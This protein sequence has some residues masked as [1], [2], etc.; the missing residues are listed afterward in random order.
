[1][2]GVVRVL[3]VDDSAYVRKVVR[4]M[5]SRSPFLEVVGAARDGEE[6]LELVEQLRPDVVTLD[7]N[8]PRLDGLDFLRRQ[9]A[10]RPVPV[11]L[12]SIASESGEQV[13][14]A[15]DAGAV[16][17]VQKPTALASEQVLEVADDLIAKVKAAASAKV[18][19]LRD[20]M[21]PAQP[22]LTSRTRSDRTDIV[23]IGVSTGGPQALKQLIPKL[24][25][26]FPVP[27]AIVLHMPMGFTEL[28]ARSLA[29]ASRLA[30]AEARDGDLVRPRLALIAPSGYHLTFS[31]RSD[32]TVTVCLTLRPLDTPHR[33]AVDVLFRSAA[34]VYGD[35]VLAVVL[36]GM[37]SDG[38]Q[39]AAWVKAQGGRVF[40]EAE[41]SCVV[42][43]MPRSV[44]EAGL[45][46]AYI[47]LPDMARAI[48]E[49]L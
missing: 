20:S 7:L 32:R 1:M 15:L 14:Q 29:E 4:Q 12:L 17:V 40:T 33:P 25:L 16:D 11:V 36:T 34:E 9:M 43:G 37:G 39:G 22:L 35:R 6:A 49:A 13:M 48:I 28:F 44:A 38:T 5:L 42:Y 27:V 47:P 31:R 10:R 8:M 30:V 23:V 46:D 41:E 26:D 18:R 24:P 3:I 19:V 2:E 45:S 21:V